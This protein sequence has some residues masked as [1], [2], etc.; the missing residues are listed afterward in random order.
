MFVCLCVCVVNILFSSKVYVT[1]VLSGKK[2]Q[3]TE[4]YTPLLKSTPN[5]VR[6]IHMSRT[7]RVP[8][9]GSS[10][11]FIFLVVVSKTDKNLTIF[12]S[13]GYLKTIRFTCAMI[14]KIFYLIWIAPTKACCWKCV[15]VR[16]AETSMAPLRCRVH[17]MCFPLLTSFIITGLTGPILCKNHFA[18]VFKQWYMSLA[19]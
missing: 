6:P 8:F 2:Q 14:I 11:V 16:G 12:F 7:F 1:E 3:M 19:C 13:S 15:A 10:R 18:T 17:L 5:S 9:F 4:E